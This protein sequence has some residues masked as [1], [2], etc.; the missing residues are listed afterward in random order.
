[1]SVHCAS[2]TLA[3]RHPV[4]AQ[5]RRR[6]RPCLRQFQLP[7]PQ[8]AVTLRRGS[9]DPRSPQTTLNGGGQLRSISLALWGSGRARSTPDDASN[10]SN[11]ASWN[12]ARRWHPSIL[13]K[14]LAALWRPS[15]SWPQPTRGAQ[16]A[17]GSNHEMRVGFR[18]P[19]SWPSL[20]ALT[21]ALEIS[22][23]ML[24]LSSAE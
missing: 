10:V 21:V 9:M 16:T 15:L 19:V 22:R 13:A 2:R 4:F 5:G 23:P 24:K 8:A 11:G 6:D 17:A 3:A 12:I 20:M 1:M 14:P 7:D 18:R